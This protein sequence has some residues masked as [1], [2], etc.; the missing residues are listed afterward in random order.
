M[1]EPVE[2]VRNALRLAF[3]SIVAP[4]CRLVVILEGYFDESG[5]HTGSRTLS[6]A[7]YVSTPERWAAF[8]VEWRAALVDFGLEFWHMAS[9]ANQA[10]QY[11]NWTEET[12]RAR[13]ARLAGIIESHALYSIGVVFATADYEAS[14][15]L[16]VRRQF[17][18]PYGAAAAEMI[19]VGGE[20]ARPQDGWMAYVL[21]S[22]AEGSGQVLNMFR[23]NERV[24]TEKEY[25]RLLSLRF[26]NKRDF[27]PL[28]AADMLAYE[29]YRLLSHNLG[30]ETRPPRSFHLGPLGRTPH[31]WRHL[32]ADELQAYGWMMARGVLKAAADPTI[33]PGRRNRRRKGRKR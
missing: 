33:R 17:G 14:I 10:G 6:L 32:P 9:F 16:F 30:A 7:G 18:G 24:A 21:E 15:P 20:Y 31:T 29:L 22:G 19:F 5:T 2:Y 4:A 12:R 23:R 27:V 25:F 8:E 1:Y 26:E 11:A 3:P 28:Q 13:F